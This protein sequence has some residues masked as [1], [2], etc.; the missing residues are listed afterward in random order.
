M[1]TK[2]WKLIWIQGSQKIRDSK[3]WLGSEVCWKGSYWA[4][5]KSSFS[6]MRQKPDQNDAYNETERKGLRVRMAKIES[7]AQAASRITWRSLVIS[8]TRVWATWPDCDVSPALSRLCWIPLMIPSNLYHSTACL[9]N[10]LTL[11][12]AAVETTSTVFRCSGRWERLQLR[13]LQVRSYFLYLVNADPS[14]G[15]NNNFY[16]NA[17]NTLYLMF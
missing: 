5:N 2:C 12:V 11:R 1:A 7:G 9:V 17:E 4:F 13:L 10:W 15:Y 6:W 14:N 8:L 3:D 16:L